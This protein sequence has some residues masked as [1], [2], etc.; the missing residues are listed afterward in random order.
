MAMGKPIV[1]THTP[2]LEDYVAHGETD[3]FVPSGDPDAMVRAL[4]ELLEDS[5]RCAELGTE[6]RK[7]ALSYFSIQALSQRLASV[8]R[9][10]L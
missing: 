6:A 5:D 7:R 10:V 3:V 1:A 9:S 4:V 8:I 2:G